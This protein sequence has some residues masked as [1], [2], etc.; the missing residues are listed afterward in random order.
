[1]VREYELVSTVTGN[2]VCNRSVEITSMGNGAAP[3]VV[4]HTSGNCGAASAG[5]QVPTQQES[6]PAR[7]KGPK[8]IMTK[9]TGGNAYAGPVQEAGLR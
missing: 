2:S 7:D 8:M 6:V 1:G 3:K 5:W 9:A 4:T